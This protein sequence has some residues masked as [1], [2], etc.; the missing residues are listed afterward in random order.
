MVRKQTL[1]ALL[2]PPA[3]LLA[4][5]CARLTAEG[6][7]AF[8]KAAYAESARL[9]Q[10]AAQACPPDVPLYVSLGQVLY[11]NGKE[12]D[13]EAWLK[14]ALAL[15]PNSEMANYA[16]G[17]IYYQQNRF[18]EAVER[19][20]LVVSVNPKN[21][22][23]WDNLGLCHDA[24]QQDAL[25]LKSFFRAL[26]LVMKDH[27][28]YDW[29]HANLADFFLKRNQFEKSFQLAAEAAR[30]NPA[31]ARNAFLTG[32]SLS[33]LDKHDLALRWLE[34]AVKLD[35]QYSEAWYLLSQTYRRQERPGDANRALE[36]FKAIKEKEKK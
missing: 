3:A 5:D 17:R 35:P 12:I 36:R 33:K 34:Q 23:A 11:L 4:D 13:A 26:D 20:N 6:R 31:S 30:R 22:R 25:A 28:T 32:K 2:I 21:Y 24:L 14:K 1:I 18:P 15:E 9:L 8:A 7:Q 10:A 29:A 16:L 19:L 27:P